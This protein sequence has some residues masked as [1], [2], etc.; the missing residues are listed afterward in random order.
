MEGEEDYSWP[1]LVVRQ[2]DKASTGSVEV[3]SH[4]RAAQCCCEAY[5][6]QAMLFDSE[7]RTLYREWSLVDIQVGTEI[8]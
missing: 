1:L 7:H 4:D 8:V 3:Y 2:Q 6:R 5:R